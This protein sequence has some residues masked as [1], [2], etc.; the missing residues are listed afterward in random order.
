MLLLSMLDHIVK[1]V[2][3]NRKELESEMKGKHIIVVDLA[4]NVECLNYFKKIA[5]SLIV[6]DD[7]PIT[8]GII[9]KTKL[10]KSEYYIGDDKHGACAYTWKFLYPKKKVPLSIQMVE[11]ADRKVFLNYLGNT[12]PFINFLNYRILMSRRFKWNNIQSF[13]RL[14]EYLFDTNTNFAKFVGHYFDEV[15][16]N[17]KEQVARNAQLRYFE[18]HPVYVLNYKDPAL[19]KNGSKT[20]ANKC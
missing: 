14:L 16:N 2:E 6:I 7:H 13:N 5:K 11:T 8:K 1:G 17:V 10:K 20:N 3:K 12:R 9:G 4:Y 19:Y 18:G 15:L